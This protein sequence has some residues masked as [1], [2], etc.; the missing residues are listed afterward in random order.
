MIKKFGGK[1]TSHVFPGE[2]LEVLMWRQ[3]GPKNIV[4]VQT[5]TKERGKV[6]FMGHAEIEAENFQPK[7]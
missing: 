2:T 5:R 4:T 7:L 1:F 3:T 6:V